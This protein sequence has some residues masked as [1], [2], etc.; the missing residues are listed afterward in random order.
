[1]TPKIALAQCSSGNLIEENLQKAD[2]YM[3]KAHR[4]GAFLIVFP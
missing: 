1:M 3:A 4:E 2:L